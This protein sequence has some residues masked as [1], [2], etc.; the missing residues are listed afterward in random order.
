MD[1][2]HDETHCVQPRQ[3]SV[4]TSKKSFRSSLPTCSGVLYDPRMNIFNF[5]DLQRKCKCKQRNR[6]FILNSVTTQI[7][8]HNVQ[9]YPIF[10]TKSFFGHFRTN[11]G[12]KI[13]LWTSHKVKM[14]MVVAIAFIRRQKE[15]PFWILTDKVRFLLKVKGQRRVKWLT[16]LKGSWNRDVPV[17]EVQLS[18]PDA[19]CTTLAVVLVACP[20]DGLRR[21]KISL[22]IQWGRAFVHQP[23]RKV[24]FLIWRRK[25]AA[26]F[27]FMVSSWL[28]L[29]KSTPRGGWKLLGDTHRDKHGCTHTDLYPWYPVLTLLAKISHILLQRKAKIWKIF[30]KFHTVKGYCSMCYCGWISGTLH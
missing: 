12:K 5:L 2:I 15:W 11:G 30:Q 10:I 25:Y 24:F 26:R 16:H 17:E 6:S 3:G 8:K 1:S 22:L 23:A 18:D 13:T 29:F 27:L 7:V 20:C 21:T 4:K 9:S 14:L 28:I 19:S